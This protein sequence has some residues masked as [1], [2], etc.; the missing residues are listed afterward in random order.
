MTR[1]SPLPTWYIEELNDQIARL[2]EMLEPLET[3]AGGIGGITLRDR[4]KEHIVRLKKAIAELPSIRNEG[5]YAA[6]RRDPA[7]EP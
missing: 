7:S 1:P 5:R 3:G 2:K 6:Q 4:S